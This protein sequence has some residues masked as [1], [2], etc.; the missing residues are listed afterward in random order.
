[1]FIERFS[2]EDYLHLAMSLDAEELSF[3]FPTDEASDNLVL[4][5]VSLDLLGNVFDP[6]EFLMLRGVPYAIVA[7]NDHKPV[8]GKCDRCFIL[9]KNFLSVD[10]DGI[11]LSFA[12]ILELSKTDIMVIPEENETLRIVT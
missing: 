2:D 7:N 1:M 9:G 11:K 8:K 6:D 12:D 5:Y 4:G 3:W 10:Y